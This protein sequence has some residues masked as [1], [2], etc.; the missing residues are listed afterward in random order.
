MKLTSP[1]RILCALLLSFCWQLGIAPHHTQAEEPGFVSLFDGKSL[2]GWDG[3][4]KFWRV[5][6]GTITG[7]TT[8]NNPTKG[9]TFIIWRDGKLDDFELRIQFR[10]VGG[11]SG[12]QYRSRELDKWVVGGYQAD[13]DA[14]GQWAGILYEE[15]GRGILCKRGKKVV[16]HPDGKLEEVATLTSEEDILKAIRKEAWNEYRIVARGNHLQQWI[17]GVQTVD[18]TDNQESKRA[19]S[20]L[21]ALQLHAGPPMT[22]QFKDIRLKRLGPTS[23]A[24]QSQERKKIVFLAGG[25]SHGYGAHE[26]YAGC[27]LLAHYL[28]ENFPNYQTVVYRGWPAEGTAALE[29][30]DAVVVYCD[31]GGRHLLNAHLDEFDSLMKQGVGLVQI[32][33]AVETV[34][35]KPG[36]KFI[37][38]MGGYF[39]P[40]WSV[41]PHWTA[42]FEQLPDHP[43]TRGVKPFEINDEWYFH[44]RFA[45]GLKGVTPILSAHP[46]KSTMSRPDGPHSGNPAVR[47]AVHRGDIQHVAWAFDR[48]D[49][50]RGFGFT[51]GH[52]HW[53][54]GNDNF[55][56]VVLNAIVWA[57]KG[58]VPEQGVGGHTPSREELEA[59]QDFPKPKTNQGARLEWNRPTETLPVAKAAE[60][61]DQRAPAHAIEGLDIHPDL[62]VKLF[63]SEPMLLSPSNIDIDHRGRVWVCEIVNYRGHNG[64]RPEGDR[65]LI[66]EDTNGD[67]Q[68]D[69][70]TVFYQGKDID[71]PH[72]V[73]VLGNRVVVSA[74]PRVIC[75][76]DRNGDD[77]PDEKQV[78]FQDIRGVQH[79]HGIHTFLFGPDGKLYFNFGNEGKQLH[80]ADG[81]PVVDMAGNQV[82]E[83]R[84]P[85][86]QGM[87]FR[88][89]LDL[90]NFETLAW[91]FRNNWMLTVDSFGTIWQ[92]D[93]DDDGNRGVRIN[94]VMEFGNYGYRDERTGESWQRPRTNME[95]D[96]PTRHWHLN[97]PGV[98]PNLLQTG[99]GSPTGI[100]VY[101]GHMLIPAL[102]GQLIHCDAGPSITRSYLV[103]KQGAGYTAETLNLVKGA[104]DQWFRP[105]DVQVA[106]DGSLIIADWYDPGVGGHQMRDLNRG[107]IFRVTRK[108]QAGRYQIPELDLSTPQAAAVALRNPNYATRYLAWSALHDMGRQA[109]SVL[110]HMYADE[111][112]RIR[113]RALWLLAKI[114]DRATHYARLAA[115]D[116]DEDLRVQSLRL[117]MQIPQIDRLGLVE[118]LVRDSSPQVR[119]QCAIA[120]R[121]QHDAQAGELWT[122]LALQHDG[123]DRWYLEALGIGADGQ[124]D[125][126][127]AAYLRQV[128]SSW[129]ASKAARDIVWRS[130]AG[131]TPLR[132]ATLIAD[133][134]TPVDE[135]P[136]YFRAFD[137]QNPS[138]VKQQALQGLA[139]GDYET[140]RLNVIVPEALSRIDRQALRSDPQA[141]TA[142]NQRLD[143]VQDPGKLVEL[144]DRLQLQSRYP[145]L[146]DIAASHPDA[147]VGVEAARTLLKHGQTL[148]NE[149]LATDR[150][151]RA[152]GLI[153]V[154]GRSADNRAV[155]LLRPL[156]QDAQRTRNQRAEALRAMAKIRRG[157]EQ[158]VQQAEKGDL[159]TDLRE[160][161]AAELSRIPWGDLRKQAVQ[162]LPPPP[163]K[164]NALLPSIRDLARLRGRIDAGRKIFM[165]A[166]TCNK[167]HTVGAEGKHVGPDLSEIGGK[168]SREALIESVLFP[169]AGISHNYETH[170]VELADG[171]VLTGILIEASDG[172]IQVKDSEGVVHRFDRSEVDSISKQP[173]SI[174]PADLQKNLTQQD[175]VDL[176]EYLTTLR[177]RDS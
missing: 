9:N 85:Y 158:L 86:Q 130:R 170:T 53:N 171:N 58:K 25:P 50:G 30:A 159:P 63:A 94:Y 107:R 22:V 26:H 97:D 111:N 36:E 157:A 99:G 29:D 74:G 139:F 45:P 124:W 10:I 125:A 33:Y 172:E 44:M 81:K 133:Q 5:Q 75:F 90:S 119:R 64:E 104:R 61:E 176:V 59:N 8:A 96:I 131:E 73:C 169:S 134:A 160:L 167:C 79:D 52:F 120:L 116:A 91:N 60:T 34:K 27:A 20:G 77:V 154:L 105:S 82:A 41:N 118:S 56:K 109:E 12:I 155:D 126:F 152:I 49:G 69:K 47:E 108:G 95:P 156:L 54:W 16:I 140:Q 135:L 122:Q 46:P 37:E 48:P 141:Q 113:A 83:H 128:G 110:Q 147:S 31:G 14:A 19:M 65:I 11:N 72:G 165:T 129:V 92:S 127:L 173:I 100:T 71:S 146:V 164:D 3:N 161:A 15:R 102:H 115:D 1:P 2:K 153:Q 55:R 151:D 114:P 148:L 68:A 143:A 4:P 7:Q 28:E 106:P 174:M 112:P 87:I 80:F 57:A 145:Q 101:E 163:T 70:R 132:L 24:V 32:H 144:I 150:S 123:Q 6:D 40:N 162:L 17:N 103:K 51:G 117:A 98:V 88:C 168:L 21:L 166:G 121:H 66:L 78:W 142:I 42:T 136:R 84:Q 89:D 76:T 149:A 137:F 35:G 13:F 62:Q 175:L 39:E 23:A 38:W 177:K 43:I 93:N 67:G 18:V 138:P